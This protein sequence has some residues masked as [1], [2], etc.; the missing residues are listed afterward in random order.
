MGAEEE[1]HQDNGNPSASNACLIRVL[2]K[3]LK[4]MPNVVANNQGQGG[5]MGVLVK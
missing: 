3:T 2:P 4:K 5:M 1:I